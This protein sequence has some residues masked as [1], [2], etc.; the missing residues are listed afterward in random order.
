MGGK[1]E[2]VAYSRFFVKKFNNKKERDDLKQVLNDIIDAAQFSLTIIALEGDKE[3]DDSYRNFSGGK[4][5]P[6]G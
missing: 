4:T 1:A 2:T 6:G 3:L 5:R